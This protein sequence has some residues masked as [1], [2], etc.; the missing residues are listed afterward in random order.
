MS[1]NIQVNQKVVYCAIV[2]KDNDQKQIQAVFPSVCVHHMETLVKFY[3]KG[4][5]YEELQCNTM[6]SPWS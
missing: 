3:Y 1:A 2:S 4:D 5:F 6:A